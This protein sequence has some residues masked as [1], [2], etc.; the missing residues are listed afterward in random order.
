M[1]RVECDS[2]DSDECYTGDNTFFVG[3]I[4]TDDNIVDD[5]EKQTVSDENDLTAKNDESNNSEF[6]IFA[7]ASESEWT[8]DMDTSGS[9]VRFKLDTG[10]QVNVLPKS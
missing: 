10:A 4:K 6:T 7:I 3:S 2:S 1:R 5:E 8:V 9:N